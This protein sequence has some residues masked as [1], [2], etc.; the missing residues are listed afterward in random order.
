MLDFLSLR[1]FEGI[2]CTSQFLAS[3]SALAACQ[4][5][6]ILV[7]KKRKR[8]TANKKQQPYFLKRKIEEAGNVSEE[9]VKGWIHVIRVSTRYNPIE[10]TATRQGK[11]RSR[12]K[13][14]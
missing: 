3:C 6:H 8:G 11:R 13:T 5:E 2:Q 4:K 1:L 14:E 7:E 10:P 12:T 9:R